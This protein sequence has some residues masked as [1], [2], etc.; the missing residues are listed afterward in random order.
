[1]KIKEHIYEKKTKR[2]NFVAG[3]KNLQNDLDSYTDYIY[4]YYCFCDSNDA[5][6]F[7]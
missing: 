5:Y 1:M 2:G 7:P 6:G 4:F 3:G